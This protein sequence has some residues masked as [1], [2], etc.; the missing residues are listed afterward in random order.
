MI[1]TPLSIIISRSVQH[2][3][4]KS[5]NEHDGLILHEIQPCDFLSA[6]SLVARNLEGKSSQCLGL[7]IMVKSALHRHCCYRFACLV[8]VVRHNC[9]TDKYQLSRAT[10]RACALIP[11]YLGLHNYNDV[12]YSMPNYVNSI[13]MMYIVIIAT[14]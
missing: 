3:C 8:H 13:T 12:I 10:P 1:T 5:A 2:A 6:I 9:P 14:V 4:A 11:L 7:C